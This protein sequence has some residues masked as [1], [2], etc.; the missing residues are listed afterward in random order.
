[1]APT[2]RK[3]WCA[4][5]D[6]AGDKTERECARGTLKNKNKNKNKNKMI[7]SSELVAP[8]NI[9]IRNDRYPFCVVW[10]ALPPITWIIPLIGHTG[11]GLE[12]SSPCFLPK[13]QRN[14]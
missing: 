6:F 7:S 12:L 13:R 5:L 14:C 4:L 3:A 2:G 1:M 9:D 10:T 11:A 8:I